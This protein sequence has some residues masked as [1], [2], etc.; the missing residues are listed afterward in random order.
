MATGGRHMQGF[1]DRKYN[2]DDILNNTT[3][4]L[5][6]LLPHLVAVD[7]HESRGRVAL[8]GMSTR[9]ECVCAIIPSTLN[10]HLLE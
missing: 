6:A 9:G 4:N 10:N 2:R 5:I 8:Y 7:A 3:N 1:F